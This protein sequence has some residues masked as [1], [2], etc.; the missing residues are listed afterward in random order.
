LGDGT[1]ISKNSPTNINVKGVRDIYVGRSFAAF[2]NNASEAFSFGQN[3]VFL[4]Y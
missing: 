3:N 4:F 2:I 1:K